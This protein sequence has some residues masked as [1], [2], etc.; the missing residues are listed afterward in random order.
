MWGRFL[1]YDLADLKADNIAGLIRFRLEQKIFYH[2]QIG[3]DTVVHPGLHTSPYAVPA[4]SHTN[5]PRTEGW[6]VEPIINDDVDLKKPAARRIEY[7]LRAA[8]TRADDYFVLIG[9]ELPVKPA[10]LPAFNRGPMDTAVQRRG[11]QNLM[12]DMIDR[13]AFVH[14]LM[15]AI[16]EYRLDYGTIGNTVKPV[17]V[18]VNLSNVPKEGVHGYDAI[19]MQPNHPETF[20]FKN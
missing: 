9:G 10:G 7:D 2:E 11:W 18:N 4:T 12:F 8:Q 20:Y 3:D 17:L 13:P 16:T 1:G 15:E 19:R 6:A 5:I 14:D